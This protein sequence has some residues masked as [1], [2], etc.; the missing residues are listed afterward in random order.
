[1]GPVVNRAQFEKIQALIQTGLDEGAT[2]AA[3]GIG[4]PPG[5]DR[6]Y[7]LRPTILGNV[8]P[9]AT[10]AQEE[11][12]GPVLSIIPYD[13]EADAIA[14]ANGTDYGLAGWVW[15]SDTERA[16]RVARAMRAGR[17]YIN[18]APPAPNVPF[19]GYRMSG[20]GREQGVFGL[21]EYLEI[22]A[23]LGYD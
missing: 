4:R 13:D 9:N 6:G 20:N 16:R 18:G 10:V 17:I 5:L 11:I 1:M 23:M 3:G 8:A 12:F 19:G 15:S 7:Y 21:E 14:I 2:L 22:K